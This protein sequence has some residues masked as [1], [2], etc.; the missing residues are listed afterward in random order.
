MKG[1][2]AIARI[3]KREGV[4][5]IFC[6][7][8]NGL[9]EACAVE[10]IRPV[11]ARTERTVLAM[12]D[13]YTRVHNGK[14]IGVCV[15]QRASGSEN[16]F[17]GVA[18]VF[19]DST[20]VLVLP[21]GNPRHH[22]GVPYAFDAK[23]HYRNTTQWVDSVNMGSRI[24]EM[25]RRAFSA[26]RNGRR[27][28]VM[29]EVPMDVA[30]E[31]IDEALVEA[32]HAPK[33]HPSMASPD[34]VAAAAQALLDAERPVI[35][36]GQGVLY[37][38]ATEELRQ[39]V[40]VLQAPIVTTMNGKGAFPE[41]HPLALGA[42]GATTTE[43]ADTFLKRAD[44]IVGVGAGFSANTYS[45]PLPLGKQMIQIT[46]DERDL[47]RDYPTDIGLIGDAKLVLRQVID[48]VTSKLGGKA[49]DGSKTA[50][51]IAAIKQSWLET[52]L[53]RL[54]SDETPISPYRVI[55]EMNRVFD[56]RNTMVTHDAGNPRDQILPFYEA[57]T[58]RG[59]IGWGKSTHLGWGY[60]LMMG[61]KLA[62]PDKLSVNFMG[63]AAFGMTGMEVETAARE[64]IGLLTVLINNQG[65]GGYDRGYPTAVQ[66]FN[67]SNLTGQYARM[68]ETLGAYGER[69]ERPADVGPALER[70]AQITMEGR[71]ALLE[72]MTRQEPVLSRFPS[73]NP[74]N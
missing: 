62:A 12:A 26:L 20:P 52:W 39:L 9:I 18:Q 36:A 6:Y 22:L 11:L 69:V 43:Q 33:S 55:W 27:G 67:F 29:I 34:D 46:T 42:A 31:E 40:E 13:G 30:S 68:A 5:L 25:L 49:R 35:V 10:G 28:P 3:L 41:D 23:D 17:G 44:L 38:E 58:P 70:A 56:Q 16:T 8:S 24:P 66:Q 53:P 47:N 14:K 65:M 71:P 15:V 74:R 19:S 32:Y 2:A 57:L 59:Y 64:K 4:E 45:H 51:E 63:D 21:G 1:N 48:A 72:I 60:G 54:T 7:P 73:G 50:A 37:A 61:A